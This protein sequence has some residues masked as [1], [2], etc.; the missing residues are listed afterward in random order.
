MSGGGIY[1]GNA[2]AI[3]GSSSLSASINAGNVGGDCSGPGEFT[4]NGYN[5][6]G[7]DCGFSS[8][9]DR[10]VHTWQPIGIGPLANNG[11][12]TRTMAL[13]IKS[14]AKD[15]IPV[16]A[17]G[18]DGLA[19]LCPSSGTTDQ[20]FVRRP[21]GSACDIGSFERRTWTWLRV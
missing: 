7:V 13:F 2:E 5:L 11:G 19:H 10:S 4:S 18:A 21:Q 9:G 3:V 20:R 1:N 17:S 12:P 6:A 16:G 14:P 8:V 15:A